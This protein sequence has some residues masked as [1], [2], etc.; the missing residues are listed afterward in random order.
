MSKPRSTGLTFLQAIL[1]GLIPAVVTGAIAIVNVRVSED[2]QD[3]RQ[4]TQIAA[5]LTA[6]AAKS[7]LAHA[8]DPDAPPTEVPTLEPTITPVPEA[9]P[10]SPI[11]VIPDYYAAVDAG[12]YLSAWNMLSKEFKLRSLDDNYP[13]YEAFWASAG[14]V[15]VVELVPIE[16]ADF[17][18]EALVRLYWETDRR[19]RAYTYSLIL[20]L[21]SNSWKIDAVEGVR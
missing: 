16:V 4:V 15:N 20:D 21:G 2:R 6:D 8:L 9:A 3:R 14:L 19:T 5:D 13:A 11:Q 7:M 10:P 1:L 12:D 17:H 18:A